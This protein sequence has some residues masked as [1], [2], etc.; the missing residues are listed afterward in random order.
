MYYFNVVSFDF[1]F[2]IFFLLEKRVF[3][4]N[5]F[6]LLF[7]YFFLIVGVKVFLGS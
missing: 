4:L 3:Y 1:S 2:N 6:Y 5:F 7:G